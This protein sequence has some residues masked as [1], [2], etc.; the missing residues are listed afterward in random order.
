MYS[1]ARKLRL[2]KEVMTERSETVLL[3][4]ERLLKKVPAET[5]KKTSIYDFVGMLNHKEA[6]TMREAIAESCETINEG[7]WK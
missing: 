1:E 4:I 6:Q 5:G 7:D 2:I 3:A